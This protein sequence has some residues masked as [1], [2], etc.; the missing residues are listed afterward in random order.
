MRALIRAWESSFAGTWGLFALAAIPSAFSAGWALVR[1]SS[2]LSAV[3][4]AEWAV[5]TVAT[6]VLGSISQLGLKPG[7]MQYVTDHGKAARYPGLRAAIA[8]LS[9]T[10][11]LAAC[12]L[13]ALLYTASGLGNWKNTSVLPWIIPAM[14][15]SNAVMMLHTDLRILGKS[16]VIAFLAFIQVPI[17]VMTLEILISKVQDPLTVIYVTQAVVSLIFGVAIALYGNIFRKFSMDLTFLKWAIGLGLPAMAALLAKYFSDFVIAGSFRWLA[18]PDEAGLFGLATKLTEPL[19][20]L[21]IGSFQMAWGTFVYGW[22]KSDPS[23]TQTAKSAERAWL[24]AAGA[25]PIG[26]FLAALVLHFSATELP[27]SGVFVFLLMCISRAAAFGISSP[28]G[29]GQTILR[30]YRIGQRIHLAELVITVALVPSSLVFLGWEMAL[31]FS[32][33]IPWLSVYLLRSYS[34][35]VRLNPPLTPKLAPIA[36]Q[37]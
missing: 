21:Y 37:T 34:N 36:R 32:A 6:T 15:I 17:F 1:L 11:L 8:L 25:L 31:I 16:S 33:T 9:A 20:A 3:D 28:M 5:L 26:L 22:I 19:M 14:T 13:I 29:F 24:Y 10:G 30:D 18:P 12:S 23:A 4:Y 2:H 27:P 7:Y 35:K